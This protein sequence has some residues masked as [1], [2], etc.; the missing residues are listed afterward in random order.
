MLAQL[1]R[2]RIST[3]VSPKQQSRGVKG[4]A[5]WTRP[6]SLAWHWTARPIHMQCAP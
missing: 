5:S 6:N 4:P 2:H 1:A 3:Q